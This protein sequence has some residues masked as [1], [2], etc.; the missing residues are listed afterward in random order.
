MTTKKRTH[1]PYQNDISL[2][3]ATHLKQLA[4]AIRDAQRHHKPIEPACERVVEA[5]WADVPKLMERLGLEPDQDKE[6][7]DGG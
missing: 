1:P 3:V 5:A 7:D 2:W 6:P 4:N